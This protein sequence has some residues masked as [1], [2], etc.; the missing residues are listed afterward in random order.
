MTLSSAT[1]EGVGEAGHEEIRRA[2]GRVVG[3][4]VIPVC[5]W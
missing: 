4:K 5:P 3:D 2:R 1:M